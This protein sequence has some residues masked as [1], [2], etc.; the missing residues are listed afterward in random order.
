MTISLLKENW[1]VNRNKDINIF[2][3]G[4]SEPH[5]GLTFLELLI[6]VLIFSFVVSIV[7]SVMWLG[8][9]MTKRSREIAQRYTGARVSLEFIARQIR[10]AFDFRF[11]GYRN[12]TWDPDNKILSLWMIGCDGLSLN[13]ASDSPIYRVT[14]YHKNDNGENVIWRKIE[15]VYPKIVPPVE[16][17]MVEGSFDLEIIKAPTEDPQDL[18]ERVT[19]HFK[20]D[21]KEELQK[22]VELPQ[23]KRF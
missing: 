19:I 4:K 6:A 7:T 13:I 15:A 20:V 1:K 16:G 14:Y 18:P 10:S 2:R 5:A 9:R 3:K 12:F 8:M 11:P 21:D 17:P 23:Y 22:T